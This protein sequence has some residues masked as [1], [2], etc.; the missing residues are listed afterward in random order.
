MIVLVTGG[1]D[2]E[3]RQVVERALHWLDSRRDLLVH[4]G[5]RDHNDRAC[6]ADWVA[7]SVARAKGV[8]VAVVEALWQNY[9]VSAGPRRNAAM[10]WLPIE[11]V[12]AFPGGRGTENCIQQ[13]ERLGIPVE[14]AGDHA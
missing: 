8:H 10:L 7:D 12:I 5:C 14:R 11:K 13:A 1:R 4:G 9:S 6:G 3:N 2:F